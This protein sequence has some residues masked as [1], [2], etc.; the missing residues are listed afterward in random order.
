MAK[1][2][3]K[4]KL[5]EERKKN[6]ESASCKELGNFSKFKKLSNTN[7]LSVLNKARQPPSFRN[8]M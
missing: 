2:K 7:V 3:E 6:K 5:M 1:E 4:K 8:S